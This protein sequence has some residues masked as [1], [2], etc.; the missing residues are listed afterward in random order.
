MTAAVTPAPIPAD[1]LRIGTGR[2]LRFEG[3]AHGSGVS[4]FL[5]DNAPGEGPDLHRHPYTET[6]TILRGRALLTVG[7]ETVEV[8]A[9][10]TVV[11][12]PRTWHRFVNAGPDRLN[13]I[14]IHASDV[15]EQ[16]F[17]DERG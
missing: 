13:L 11:V 8:G 4:F 3:S 10:T 14:G 12:P 2:S 5:V 7:D 9:G 15:I 1:A 6:F 17:R 16:E